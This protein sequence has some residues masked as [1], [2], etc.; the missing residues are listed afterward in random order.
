MTRDYAAAPADHR[1]FYAESDPESARANASGPAIL[2][3]TCVAA[4]N[5][6]QGSASMDP[7]RTTLGN[8]AIGRD[9]P[10]ATYADLDPK[11][12]CTYSPGIAPTTQEDHN[13]NLDQDG[14]ST[15]LPGAALYNSTPKATNTDL[16][17][18]AAC[19]YLP[20]VALAKAY[21]TLYSNTSKAPVKVRLWSKYDPEKKVELR[22]SKERFT[23][24]S[25]GPYLQEGPEGI[26]QCKLMNKLQP[27]SVSRINHPMQNRHLLENLSNFNI[28]T[29]EPQGAGPGQ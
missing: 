6:D 19:T 3:Y 11:S 26:V 16:D 10:K 23:D 15:H 18:E 5:P 25:I 14:A 20:G 27:G 24:L 21:D 4:T 1:E 12:A 9:N 28:V 7:P 29:C 8:V 22:S 2:A 17:P 13:T